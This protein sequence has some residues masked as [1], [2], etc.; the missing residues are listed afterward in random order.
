MKR[1]APESVLDI[2]NEQFLVLLFMV[3]AERYQL[4]YLGGH[5]ARLKQLEHVLIDMGAILADFLQRGARESI[6]QRFFRLLPHGV[7]IGVKKIPKLRV[8][9]LVSGQVLRK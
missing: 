9:R 4:L 5:R 1:I 3:Q 7:V 6:A 2:G 8:K